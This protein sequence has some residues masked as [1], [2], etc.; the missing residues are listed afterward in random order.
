MLGGQKERAR[1]ACAAVPGPA[2]PLGLLLLRRDDGVL[3]G[4]AKLNFSTVFLGILTGSPVR[5]LRPMRSGRSTS[6]TLPRPGSVKPAGACA[7]TSAVS[8]SRTLPMSFL[9]RPVS[10]AM[11]PMIAVL[12]SALSPFFAFLMAILRFSLSC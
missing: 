6:F 9:V 10:S 12:V 11:Q 8:V 5:G 1:N 7:Y 4:L 2:F 3:G